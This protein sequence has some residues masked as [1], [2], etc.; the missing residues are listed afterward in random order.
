MCDENIAVSVRKLSQMSSVIPN[1]L[2]K[3]KLTSLAAGVVAGFTTDSSYGADI[4]VQKGYDQTVAPRVNELKKIISNTLIVNTTWLNMGATSISTIRN[5]FITGRQHTLNTVKNLFSLLTVVEYQQ[6][7]PTNANLINEGLD[8]MRK[9]GIDYDIPLYRI[10]NDANENGIVTAITKFV[11]RMVQSAKRITEEGERLPILDESQIS[12]TASVLAGAVLGYMEEVPSSNVD[13]EEYYINN[14]YPAVST[15]VNELIESRLISTEHLFATY[16]STIETRYELMHEPNAIIRGVLSLCTSN[17]LLPDEV[18]K[19]IQDANREEYV[20][21]IIAMVKGVYDVR[22][23]A[24]ERTVMHELVGLP[25]N[26]LH[27]MTRHETNDEITEQITELMA[28]SEAYA[29]T[30]YDFDESHISLEMSTKTM[31]IAMMV[32][33]AGLMAWAVYATFFSKSANSAHKAGDI[34]ERTDKVIAQVHASIKEAHDRH[35]T[36]NAMM[37]DF[38]EDNNNIL[39]AI[40]KSTEGTSTKAKPMEIVTDIA[41][42]IEKKTDTLEV[43]LNKLS[44]TITGNKPMADLSEVDIN[45]VLVKYELYQK[46]INQG[47]LE[48]YVKPER[49]SGLRTVEDFDNYFETSRMRIQRAITEYSPTKLPELSTF[50]EVKGTAI[51]KYLKRN[52]SH[53]NQHSAKFKKC[54]EYSEEMAKKLEAVDKDAQAAQYEKIVRGA[55]KDISDEDLKE[56]LSLINKLHRLIQDTYKNVGMN[57]NKFNL[58]YIAWNTVVLK[59]AKNVNQIVRSLTT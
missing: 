9:Y 32:L 39:I 5:V 43:T 27:G 47:E 11:E 24:L 41:N 44:F 42:S 48:Q 56:C 25:I 29:L 50:P 1:R 46:A 8:V 45:L 22:K 16:R 13:F 19:A 53:D 10:V 59:H 30:A 55:I 31:G 49:F 15:D 4:S 6:A 40:Q 20:E 36:L 17:H 52:Y 2:E 28:S 34:K 18:V 21:Y 3:I 26:P 12:K 14:A 37:K 38:E 7:N 57:Y 23:D 58:D 35:M 51:Q 33:G 54:G